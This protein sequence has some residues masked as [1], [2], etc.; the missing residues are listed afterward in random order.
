LVVA[1][2]AASTPYATAKAAPHNLHQSS[3]I[4]VSIAPCRPPREI[5]DRNLRY[6]R[7]EPTIPEAGTYDT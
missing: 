5:F 2:E 6:L 7:P 1:Q 4:I 3:L